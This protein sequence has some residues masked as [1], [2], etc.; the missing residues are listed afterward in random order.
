MYILKFVIAIKGIKIKELEDI[1][2]NKT[3]IIQWNVKKET[4]T[5]CNQ[6]KYLILVILK[7]NITHIW[8]KK[9]IKRWKII[10]QQPKTVENPNIVEIKSAVIEYVRM[11][12]KLFK[13]IKEA[14]NVSTDSPLCSKTEKETFLN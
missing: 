3:V 7:N 9:M 2:L 10:F 8:K 14:K 4:I 12:Q 1:F 11:S 13:N 6:E 5:I